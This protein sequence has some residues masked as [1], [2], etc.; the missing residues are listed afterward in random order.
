MT[1]DWKRHPIIIK[2]AQSEKTVFSKIHSKLKVTATDAPH[3]KCLKCCLSRGQLLGH[4]GT[5]LF[6][7]S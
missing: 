7:D 5:D 2:R 3:S 6:N 4:A 1:V